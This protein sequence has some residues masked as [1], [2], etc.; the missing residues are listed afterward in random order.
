[1]SGGEH[2]GYLVTAELK[3]TKILE[4]VGQSSSSVNSF[5]GYDGAG[6]DGNGGAGDDNSHGNNPEDGASNGAHLEMM[7]DGHAMWSPTV[8]N[9]PR[10]HENNIR[11]RPATRGLLPASLIAARIGLTI[12]D[13][14]EEPDSARSEAS[15]TGSD[16]DGERMSVMVPSRDILKMSSS[17]HFAEVMR[18]KEVRSCI[19]L[20]FASSLW[21]TKCDF[22]C[23]VGREAK[24]GDGEG[25]FRR[26]DDGQASEAEPARGRRQTCDVADASWCGALFRKGRCCSQASQH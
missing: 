16:I 26:G 12:T 10:L 17:R 2:A 18:K 14:D 5:G 19:Y 25:N 21:L 9:D 7:E 11:V 24:G 8:N 20:F 3:L 15:A 23:S 13:S 6:A 22:V 4:I 1:M